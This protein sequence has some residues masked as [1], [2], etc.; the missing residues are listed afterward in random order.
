METPIKILHPHH[1]IVKKLLIQKTK[2]K[3]L[4]NQNLFTV[5]A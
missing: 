3:S 5:L 4:E 2:Q 1:K